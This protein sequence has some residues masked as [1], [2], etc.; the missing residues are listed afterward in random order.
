MQCAGEPSNRACLRPKLIYIPLYGYTASISANLLVMYD[1]NTM[2][3]L[4]AILCSMD[5]PARLADLQPTLIA[6]GELFAP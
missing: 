6:E 1:H 3:V 2:V 5:V 4:T